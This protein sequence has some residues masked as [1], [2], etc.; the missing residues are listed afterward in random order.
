MNAGGQVI[1]TVGKLAA[2]GYA[3]RFEMTKQN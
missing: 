1:D 3:S 2:E